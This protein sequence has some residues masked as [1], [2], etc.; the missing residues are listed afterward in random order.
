MKG[1]CRAVSCVVTA[2][3]EPA[4]KAAFGGQSSERVSGGCGSGG[5]VG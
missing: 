2:S 3:E 5:G 4:Q 1:G